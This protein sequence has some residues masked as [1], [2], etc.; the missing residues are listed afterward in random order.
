[1]PCQKGMPPVWDRLWARVDKRSWEE[2]WPWIGKSRHK[3]GYGIIYQGNGKRMA[4]TSRVAYQLI[5]GPLA[6]KQHVLHRCDNP[7]CCNPHHLFVGTQ[8]D[9][10][11]DALSKGRIRNGSDYA[12]HCKRGHKYPDGQR[13]CGECR[14]ERGR[15]RDRL[16][17]KAKYVREKEQRHLAR[18]ARNNG[19]PET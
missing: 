17:Y 8:G 7:A 3:F 2:C 15:I 12:T 6:S 4:T 1:M 19:N 5:Y 9:N 13:T 18:E 11:R 14:R 16:R 10:V